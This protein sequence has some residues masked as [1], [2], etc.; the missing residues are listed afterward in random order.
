M[1]WFTQVS[2]TWN[3]PDHL[4]RRHDI[5]GREDILRQIGNALRKL[6][7]GGDGPVGRRGDQR[8]ARLQSR[9]GAAANTPPRSAG[10]GDADSRVTTP[11]PPTYGG[12]VSA[13]KASAVATPNTACEPTGIRFFFNDRSDGAGRM[14]SC[15]RIPHCR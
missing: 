13:S 6:A 15:G 10:R 11:P 5:E 12:Y 14:P 4:A 3:D 8:P 7:E 1:R 9:I 2:V